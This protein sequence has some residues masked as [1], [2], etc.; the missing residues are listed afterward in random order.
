MADYRLIMSLLLKGR[1]YR[2]CCGGSGLLA[3]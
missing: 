2:G 1:S 3:S